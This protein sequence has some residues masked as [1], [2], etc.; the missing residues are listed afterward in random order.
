LLLLLTLAVTSKLT[1]LPKM[2]IEYDN[3]LVATRNILYNGKI[4]A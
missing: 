2:S 4:Y 1:A 3:M